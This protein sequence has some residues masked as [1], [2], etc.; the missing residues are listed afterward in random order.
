MFKTDGVT[1]LTDTNG[2]SIPDTGT[3]PAGGIYVV[4]LRV[5]VPT[6]SPAMPNGPYAVNK[7]ATSFLDPTK[8]ATAT[9]TLT[10]IAPTSVDLTNGSSL[11]DGPFVDVASTTVSGNPGTTVIIPLTVENNGGVA[12]TYALTYSLNSVF[13]PNTTPL[14]DGYTVIFRDAV[15]NAVVTNTDVINA[16][17]AK[18]FIAEVFIPAGTSAGVQDIYFRAFSPTSNTGDIIRD[19]IN[20]NAVNTISVEP[21]QSGQIYQGG[22]VVY[23]HTITNNGNS[24]LANVG[25]TS[26]DSAAGFVSVVYADTNNNGVLDP[27][28]VAAGPITPIT[29]IPAGESITVFVQVFAP[30]G[31]TPSTTNITTV[32]ASSG[33]VTDNA[34]DTTKVVE[35]ALSIEKFQSLDNVT[36][37]KSNLSAPP[38]A[39]IY[40]RIVV[41]NTGATLVNTVVISD[42]TPTSTTYEAGT[43]TT[44]GPDEAAVFTK[45]GGTTYVAGSAPGDGN[46]GL[47]TF[48]VGDL[49]PGQTAT[50]TFS[51]RIDGPSLL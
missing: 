29:S 20:V 32:T 48:S 6:T 22:S 10:T 46:A 35:G 33:A 40:Y 19:A 47:V 5:T 43:G 3:L 51:V 50:A 49:L 16:N 23:A 38:N 12:D 26:T 28:D 42:G 37:T 24:P 44:T 36:F 27:D 25:V 8:T 31:A 18:N 1:P 21:D 9:D 7:T 14:P 45:D 4:V 11:G 39:R 15:T 17:T 34:K 30:L 2:N 41:R 13:S